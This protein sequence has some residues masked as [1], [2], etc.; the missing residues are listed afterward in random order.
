MRVLAG[1]AAWS[2]WNEVWRPVVC[3]SPWKPIECC[4]PW[5]L[6]WPY[7]KDD[8]YQTFMDGKCFYIQSC[9]GCCWWQKK[10]YSLNCSLHTETMR[11]CDSPPLWR[12]LVYPS[13]SSYVM[14]STPQGIADTINYG[15]FGSTLLTKKCFFKVMRTIS[16]HSS[17]WQWITFEPFSKLFFIFRRF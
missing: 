9:A 5:F 6:Y 15:N 3:C 4:G 1:E 13:R 8:T 7:E 2:I 17:A 14:N 11:Y 16:V 10:Q 12:V